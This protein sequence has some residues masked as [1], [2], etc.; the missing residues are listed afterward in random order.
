MNQ[1]GQFIESSSLNYNVHW[2]FKPRASWSATAFVED[3]LEQR[4]GV[5]ETYKRYGT[6]TALSYEI[7]KKITPTFSYSYTQR[8]TKLIGRSYEV[9]A[10]T[11]YL[12]Y[13]F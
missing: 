9:N 12:A 3:G 8:S 10:V 1:G 11:L 7:M 13:R 4:S 2:R 6:G 5:G